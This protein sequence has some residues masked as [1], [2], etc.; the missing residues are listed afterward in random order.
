MTILSDKWIEQSLQKSERPSPEAPIQQELCDLLIRRCFEDSTTFAIRKGLL[1]AAA[2]D[3]FIA[4][5]YYS[6]VTHSRWLYSPGQ[7][8]RLFFSLH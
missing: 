7:Q 5:V 4:A 8:P 6:A 2:F 3:L 1:L